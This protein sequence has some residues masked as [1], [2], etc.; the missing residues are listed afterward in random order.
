MK[1]LVGALAGFILFMVA[2][3]MALPSLVRLSAQPSAFIYSPNRMYTFATYWEPR[4]PFGP[5]DGV[6]T[7]GFVKV[8]DGEGHVFDEEQVDEIQSVRVIQWN[9]DSVQFLYTR[10]G[11]LMESALLLPS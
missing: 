4:V 1:L 7:P 6:G 3:L 9:R 2:C 11:V 5:G 10:H 8:F